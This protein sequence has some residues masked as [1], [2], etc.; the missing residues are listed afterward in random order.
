MTSLTQD[1]TKGEIISAYIEAPFDQ[2]K[3]LLE[4]N[5]YRLITLEENA[6]LRMQEGAKA[7]C[8]RNGNWVQEDF[9]YIK[10]KGVILPKGYSPICENAE[11]ATACHKVNK[12]LYLTDEQV[13]KSLA[14]YILLSRNANN[15]EIPTNDFKNNDIANYIFGKSSEDYGK[16]LREAGINNMPLWFANLENKSFARKVWFWYLGDRSDLNGYDKGLGNYYWS[17]GVRCED[18][19]AS[20]PKKIA[21]A[22][23]EKQIREAL[24]EANLSEIEKILFDKLNK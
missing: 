19:I 5:K 10:G 13:E 22:Y 24:K 16:F 7:Y 17:R 23:T 8:S 9:I 6:K 20:E 21:E 3:E 12:E 15:F 2:G 18:A 1:V 14:N 4:S 11:Q